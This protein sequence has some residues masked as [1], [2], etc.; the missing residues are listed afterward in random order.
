MSHTVRLARPLSKYLDS[1]CVEGEFWL[2]SFYVVG[3]RSLY[4]YSTTGMKY[5]IRCAKVPDIGEA[6]A[7]LH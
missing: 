6:S 5:K 2:E 7:V 4:H 3:D 1:V